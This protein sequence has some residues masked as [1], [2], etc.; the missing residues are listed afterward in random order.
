M[1]LTVSTTVDIQNGQESYAQV[2]Y[3]KVFSSGDMTIHQLLCW[4][5]NIQKQHSM[6]K[7]GSD[8]FADIWD[9]RIGKVAE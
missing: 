6:H 3:T 5:T 8:Y 1:K 2:Q 4:A 9:I 7:L